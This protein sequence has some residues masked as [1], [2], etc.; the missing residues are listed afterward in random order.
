MHTVPL[1]I[2]TFT[3]SLLLEVARTA[4]H[5]EHA[6]I[7]VVESS[8]PSSPAQFS[9]LRAGE[10]DI[11]LTSP[12]NVL[13]YRFLSGNP[14]GENLPVQIIAAIDRGL[15]LSLC[16]APA[17]ASVAAVRGQVVGVDV[18]QSGF[19]FVAFELLA[20]SG[21]S[22]R[23]YTVESLGSTP[24]RAEALLSA[25]CSATVLNAGNEL[26][27]EAG[28]CHIVSRVSDIGPY[29][30]TVLAALTT[31]DPAIEE[32]RGRLAEALLATSRDILAGRWE[33]EVIDAATRLLDLS[34]IEAAAHRVC[35]MDPA[36]G[37]IG[38][39]AV[40]ADSVS[41]LIDLRRR[42]RPTPEL[43]R[44]ETSWPSLL[45]GPARGV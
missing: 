11:V 22:S 20:R 42:H 1:R 26:R 29:L 34:V 16:T 2:G 32:Q 36:H 45:T 25:G 35:L 7:E 31:T 18:P 37:L 30:G 6:G 3:R 41:T 24:R 23:D 15:G 21:L 19:A 39:G 40:D 12:D 17:L 28:G 14:L 8:V 27:A 10:L 13:A 9:A 5:L 33:A 4:G 44:V 38:S 43:D